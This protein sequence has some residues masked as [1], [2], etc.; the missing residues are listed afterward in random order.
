MR[1]RLLDQYLVLIYSSTWRRTR[2]DYGVSTFLR[3]AHPRRAAWGYPQARA[4]ARFPAHPGMLAHFVR[5]LYRKTEI[6]LRNETAQT[7]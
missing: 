7:Q 6:N 3:S 1:L 5:A 2:D 4:H